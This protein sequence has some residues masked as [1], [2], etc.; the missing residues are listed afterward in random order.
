M[1]EASLKERALSRKMDKEAIITLESKGMKVT[2]PDKKGFIEKSAAVRQ[3][4]GA[5][6]KEVGDRIAALA[7]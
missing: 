1:N 3:K 4:Y 7:E 2:Y 6:F 5:A